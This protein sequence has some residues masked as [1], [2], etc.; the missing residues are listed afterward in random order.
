[1]AGVRNNLE[2]NSYT[3]VVDNYVSVV[4]YGLLDKLVKLSVSQA[5]DTSSILVQTIVLVAQLAERWFVVP[6]VVGSSPI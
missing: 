6:M 4:L 5:E 1:M 2:Q 3:Q